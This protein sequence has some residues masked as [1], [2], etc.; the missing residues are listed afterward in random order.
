MPKKLNSRKCVL[1]VVYLGQWPVWF[2]AFLLSCKQNPDFDWLIFSDCPIP[3]VEIPNVKFIPFSMEKFNCLASKKLA[4]PINIEFPYKLCD[5]RPAF[6][7]LFEEY[8]REYSFWLS[9]H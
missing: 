1:I 8:I 6:G 9:E 4:L 2:P 5:F 7:I 3:E